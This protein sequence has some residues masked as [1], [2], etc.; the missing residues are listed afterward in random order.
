MRVV[1]IA[2]LGE[3]PLACF[4][5]RGR[6]HALGHRVTVRMQLSQ[7]V[8]VTSVEFV[9][10]DRKPRFD[11]QE[12]EGVWHCRNCATSLT[13][14]GEISLERIKLLLAIGYWLLVRTQRKPLGGQTPG[15]AIV[16]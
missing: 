13:G 10:I 12:I 15:R 11:T 9:R 7:E 3:Y 6:G 1:D 8:T 14:R 4:A 5:S 16:L 2:E